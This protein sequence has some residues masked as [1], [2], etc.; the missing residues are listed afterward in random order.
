MNR[1]PVF[2][3]AAF[4]LAIAAC[5]PTTAPPAA[6]LPMPA[7]D[8][9]SVADLKGA[10]GSSGES[11]LQRR[12]YTVARQQGLTS[13]WSHPAGN[14]VRVVTANGRYATVATVP[15]SNCGGGPATASAPSPAGASI[16]QAC[17]AAVT[18]KV[19][20]PGSSV[21]SVSPTPTGSRVLVRVPDA[22]RP[23]QCD[24][25]GGRVTNVMFL[26]EG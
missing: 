21:I 10:R 8:A 6:S 26:G 7:A 2:F 15:A 18:S 13:F 16:E 5:S 12:G 3:G 20:K 25:Q 22:Q 14:C 4:S 17:I 11:E 19:N 23:W 24:V 1:F 9:P